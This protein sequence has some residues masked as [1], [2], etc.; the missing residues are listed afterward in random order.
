MLLKNFQWDSKSLYKVLVVPHSKV[1]FGFPSLAIR[2]IR[3]DAL[4]IYCHS[5]YTPPPPPKKNLCHRRRSNDAPPAACKTPSRASSAMHTL[6]ELAPV[7]L[8]C[9]TSYKVSPPVRTNE[10]TGSQF[11]GVL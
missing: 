5:V 7:Q 10:N 2:L 4:T 3:R 8:A 9:G 6:T 1:S 11:V